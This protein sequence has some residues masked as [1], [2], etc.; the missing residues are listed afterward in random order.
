MR[1]LTFPGFL[2][3]YV[4]QLSA[5]NSGA[6]YALTHE[7]ISENPRLKEP[8]FL[9]ALSTGRVSTLMKAARGTPLESEY[10]Q[11]HRQYNYPELLAAFE[12]APS[13]LPEGYRKVWNSYLSE[14]GAYER[15]SR[16]KEL[17][18]IRIL[19]MQQKKEISTY[20]ICKDL[21]LNNANVNAWLKNADEKKVS[22]NTARMIIK[23]AEQYA[24]EP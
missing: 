24:S 13:T 3:R 1:Q 5:G 11:M 20:R 14:A 18:R 15:D 22:L 19:S 12:S 16:V 9:Y 10:E 6:L 17:M 7:T 4:R 23:F 21:G 2:D 8:L